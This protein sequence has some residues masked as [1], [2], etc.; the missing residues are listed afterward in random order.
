MIEVLG[1]I[2]GLVCA[3][4]VGMGWE[5]I[6]FNS[7][8]HEFSAQEAKFKRASL[9]AAEVVHF[10]EIDMVIVRIDCYADKVTAELQD[11]KSWM[12]ENTPSD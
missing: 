3:F 1:V 11:T 2:G 7:A 8:L 6:G 4:M 9:K 5:R 12:R 10:N